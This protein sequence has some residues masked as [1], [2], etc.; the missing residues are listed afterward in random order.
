VH[1]TGFLG[2]AM[3]QKNL[4][5]DE[6]GRDDILRERERVD[7]SEELNAYLGRNTEWVKNPVPNADVDACTQNIGSD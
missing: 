6:A 1:D 5:N 4:E 7:G 3:L 2:D